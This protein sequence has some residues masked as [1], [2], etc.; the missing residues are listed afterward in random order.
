L[1][2]ILEEFAQYKWVGEP[3]DPWLPH[4]HEPMKTLYCP[5]CDGWKVPD[6]SII[7]W[8]TNTFKCTRGAYDEERGAPK[9][10]LV[11]CPDCDTYMILRPEGYYGKLRWQWWKHV[12]TPISSELGVSP[13]FFNILKERIDSG[14][15]LQ[16]TFTGRA[17]DG[18]TYF[19][20]KMAQILNPWTTIDEVVFTREE[21]INRINT[22]KPKTVICVDETSY[23]GGKRTWQNP[24]QQQIMLIW[25][26][27]R[28]KLLPVF[29]TVINISLLDKTLREHLIVYQVNVTKRGKGKAYSLHPHP[30]EDYVGK[31]LIQTIHLPMPD[32][33]YCKKPSCLLPKCSLMDSCPLLRGQYE[34]KKE[35]IQS[36]RYRKAEEAV[37]GE[38]KTFIEWLEEF[39][40]IKHRCYSEV[41]GKRK[42]DREL[43]ELELGCSGNMAQRI[44]QLAKRRTDDE[45]REYI[46]KYKK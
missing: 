6:D 27:M 20:L 18:K 12:L 13:L 30:L 38:T 5:N 36:Q 35:K 29:S 23:I 19:M 15:S 16:V 28:Y 4:F 25:E 22:A 2:A 8:T 44:R 33:N 43:I 26:S 10:L 11:N 45:I 31:H 3:P 1:T 42:L 9:R 14:K 21:F 24:H 17:G 39:M 41:A 7:L 32:F 40:K 46:K 37:A 34:K